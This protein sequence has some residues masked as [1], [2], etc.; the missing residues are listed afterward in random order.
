[1]IDGKRPSAV[2]HPIR[3]ALAKPDKDFQ[4]AARGFF[5]MSVLPPLPP[6]AAQLGLDGFKRIEL[7]WGFQ[8]DALYSV[9]RVVAPSPRR[10][11]LAF[12]DQPTFGIRTLPPLPAAQRSGFLVLSVDLAKTFDQIIA[13]ARELNPQLAEQVAQLE[14]AIQRQFG[15]A[16]REEL[17][18]TLAPSWHF[19]DR[20]QPRKRAQTRCPCSCRS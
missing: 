15:I 10:G 5:D 9:V 19:M 1:M 13:M 20:L 18:A 14:V 4:S 6:A 16:L 2:D 3:A 8:D 7:E 12:L 17:L 11:V